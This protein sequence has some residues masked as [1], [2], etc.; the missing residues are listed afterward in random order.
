[1]NEMIEKAV[2]H[3]REL[4]LAQIARAEGK[5]IQV[6]N[7]YIGGCSLDRHFRNMMADRADY[8]MQYNGFGTAFY[9]SIKQALLSREWVGHP[10]AGQQQKLQG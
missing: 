4:L 10:A 2:A 8:A 6:T 5:D 7:L 9:V 3:Y 1:M